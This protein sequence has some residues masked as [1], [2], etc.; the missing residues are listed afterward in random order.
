V[1]NSGA[2]DRESVDSLLSDLPDTQE[3][4]PAVQK[5][6]SDQRE[7]VA[8]FVDGF[9]SRREFLLWCQEA[10]VLTLGELSGE[11]FV[12]R[13]FSGVDMS[14][15]ITSDRRTRWVP[16]GETPIDTETA[17][18]VRRG[19]VALDVLPACVDAH[20]RL[21]WSATEYVNDADDTLQPDPDAQKHPAMRP[22]LTEASD[23]QDWA[24]KRLLAGFDSHDA[25]LTW[26]QVLT[27]AA[28][29]ELDGTL[30]KRV[31]VEDTRT[32]EMLVSS[33]ED[34]PEAPAFR[35]SFAAFYLLPAFATA[36]R[37]VSDRA[38]ELAE[39][40]TKE[41]TETLI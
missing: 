6:S 19:V 10:A 15:V 17:H 29:A 31:L 18:R 30:A 23:R 12:K 20:R 13:A 38:G 11:W 36:A 26:F 8:S 35:E 14:V 1:S 9:A 37:E 28:Y 2:F 40:E 3:S 21:R 16:S 22:A 32:I 7:L 34:Q 25:V 41:I 27:E 33:P 5:L 24:L 4:R 39:K